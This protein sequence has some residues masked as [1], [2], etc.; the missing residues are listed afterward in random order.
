MDRLRR[1]EL[2]VR[3]AEAGS[4]ARAAWLLQLD[5]STVSHAVADLE[6]DLGLRLFNRTT[7]QLGLTDE[8]KDVVR[9]AR[10]LLHDM[11][12][13]QNMALLARQSLEG[14]LRVGMSVSVSQHVM[15]PHMA[16]F[17]RQ[18]PAM[19]LESL[20]LNQSKD[21]HAAGLDVMFHSGNPRDSE[22]VARRVATLRLAVYAAPSY[23]ARMGRPQHPKD[24]PSHICLVH[25]PSFIQRGWNDWEFSKGA[26]RLTV[27]VPMNLMT[28][29][30]EGLLTTAL[31]GGGIV[32]VGLVNPQHVAD[33]R[34]VR[35]LEEWQCPGGPD[36]YVLYRK[37][38]LDNPR[39]RAFLEFVDQVFAEFDPKGVSLQHHPRVGEG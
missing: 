11:A 4:F 9:R 6:K 24:L 13:L 12:D 22:L 37:S 29:D 31:H 8:G 33:G 20:I 16:Q 39:V 34:L 38:S 7:R 18:H 3:A 17:L 25:K 35:V 28:D 23:L 26:Q 5:P 19:R 21:L 30:R 2:F 32:R 1:L 27:T 36:L 10:G 15:M 14:T